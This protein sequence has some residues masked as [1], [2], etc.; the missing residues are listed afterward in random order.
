MIE[1]GA[2]D[3]EKLDI[4]DSFMF[5]RV[6]T[7]HP[8]LLQELLSRILGEPISRIEFP[9]SEKTIKLAPN[10]HG[11]RMDVYLDDEDGTIYDVEMEKPGKAHWKELLPKRSRYYQSMIDV[12]T[13]EKGKVYRDLRKSFVIFICLRDPFDRDLGVYTFRNACREDTSLELGDETTKVF[14]NTSGTKGAISPEL[15]N[16]FEYMNKGITNDSYTESLD[17]AVVSARDDL[18]WR[19][20]YMSIFFAMMDAE[21]EARER[22]LEQGK[23]QGLEQGREQGREQGYAMRLINQVLRKRRK[24]KTPAETADELEASLPEIEA[25]YRAI[26][27]AGAEADA[28]TVYECLKNEKYRQ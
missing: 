9:E 24:D 22:G 7:S 18:D 25:I 12:S 11:I 16:V 3:F 14:V 27:A 28:E 23:E 13:L 15:R 17:A 4:C 20:D 8:E 19:N 2:I 26:E 5:T 21:M 1:A 10:S 6:M